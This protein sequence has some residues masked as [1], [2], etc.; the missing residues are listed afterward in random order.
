MNMSKEDTLG[1]LTVRRS[2]RR[3]DDEG[4]VGGFAAALLT[5]ADSPGRRR[6]HVRD[7]DGPTSCR[8]YEARAQHGQECQVRTARALAPKHASHRAAAVRACAAAWDTS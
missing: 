8:H 6:C 4:C 2:R 7:A 1:P 3:G 5:S